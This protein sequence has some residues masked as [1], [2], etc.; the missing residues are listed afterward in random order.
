MSA[1]SSAVLFSMLSLLTESLYTFNSLS[2]DTVW[3]RSQN[4][5]LFLRPDLH[6]DP[7]KVR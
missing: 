7:V 5:E 4:I 3:L 2:L 1:A 6:S